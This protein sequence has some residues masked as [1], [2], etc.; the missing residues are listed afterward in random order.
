MN[1]TNKVSTWR[2]VT[3]LARRV[4]PPGELRCTVE[5]Y[6]RQ[7]TDD[8]DR[9]QRPFI[10]WPSYTMCR[11]ASNKAT[12]LISTLRIT[13]SWLLTGP[14]SRRCDSTELNW[15]SQFKTESLLL[16]TTNRKWYMVSRIAAFSMSLS[17]LSDHSPTAGLFKCEFSYNCAAVTKFQLT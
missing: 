7:T 1:L 9:R 6:R 11:R 13:L 4:L 5:C 12:K 15:T 17:G 14:C 2:N 16:R 3:L 8:Y 10:V